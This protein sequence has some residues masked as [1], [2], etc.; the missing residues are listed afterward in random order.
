MKTQANY[1][2]ALVVELSPDQIDTVRCDAWED[3][4]R[5]ASQANPFLSTYN[6]LAALQYLRDA[7]EDV[8]L[9]LI[10]NKDNHNQL[11]ALLPLNISCSC[12]SPLKVGRFWHHKYSFLGVPLIRAGCESRTMHALSHWVNQSNFNV[13]KIPL[14]Y[15]DTALTLK[16]CIPETAI[17]DGQT[18]RAALYCDKWQVD[19]FLPG[20][21]KKAKEFRRLQRRLQEQGY[22]HARISDGLPAQA[23]TEMFLALEAAGWKG[24]GR[25]A[26]ANKPAD[27]LY[28]RELLQAGI[29]AG[30]IR[31]YA[32]H[33]HSD[34]QTK[35]MSDDNRHI[36]GKAIAALIT[37][38]AGDTEMMYK[39][40]YL[41]EYARHSPGV[42]NIINY[43]EGVVKEN[44]VVFVDSCAVPDHPMINHL[45]KERVEMCTF[46]ICKTDKATAT[47]LKLRVFYRH[48]KWCAQR[49]IINTGGS[50]PKKLATE[51]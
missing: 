37:L 36:E 6:L 14:M 23:I 25:T 5:N 33:R 41:E 17:I 32:L 13:V 9:L 1:D 27:E 3:L 12:W 34:K 44:S 8:I 31:V 38:R 39:T 42:I 15:L 43:S 21:K 22:V 48:I 18:Q 19:G 29:K 4:S 47:M 35:D 30:D 16:S 40:S 2:T 11:D 24:R 46:S 51:K 10:W 28:L 50:A 7:N 26:F 45:W 49:F 20:S